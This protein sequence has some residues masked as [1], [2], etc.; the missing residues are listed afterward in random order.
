MATTTDS[1]SV[2]AATHHPLPDYQPGQ[3]LGGRFEIVEK[4]GEGMLGAVYKAR[5]KGGGDVALKVIRRGLMA[6]NTTIDQF[7]HSIQEARSVRNPRIVRVDETGEHD[8]HIF[9]TAE[10]VT[11]KTL[12]DMLNDYRSRNEDVPPREVFDVLS[13]VLDVLSDAH[14]VL[15]RNLKP[16]NIAFVEKTGPD[17]KKVRDVK[18]LDFAVAQIITPTAF[19]DSTMSREGAWYLAPEMGEFGAKADPSADLYS[20]GAIFYEMLTGYPPVGRYEMPSVIRHGEVSEKIDDLIEIA[21]NPNPQDRFHTAADMKAAL[22]STY[23]ELFGGGEVNLT[24]TL[25]LLGILIL[26]VIFASFYF[27]SSEKSPEELKAEEMA[28]RALVL[29]DV[30]ASQGPPEAPAVTDPKYADMVWIPGGKALTGHFLAFDDKGMAGER[31]EAVVDVPGYWIDKYEAHIPEQVIAPEDD[32]DTANAKR[33]YNQTQ[34][35]LLD[36]DRTWR[37][38]NSICEQAGKRLCTEDE[39]EKAC[40]G[41]DSLIYPYG[42][43]FVAKQCP[44][45]GYLPKYPY[46]EHVACR[47]A[48]GVFNLGGGAMEW[49]SSKRGDNYIVKPGALGNDGQGTRCAGRFDRAANF[50]Q[51]HVG[52]RC[53]A[54]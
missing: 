43:E 6:P 33:N 54:D 17:G 1:I 18:L 44:S 46:N 15:H 51:I 8:G 53:C 11:G 12:R 31:P 22:E 30:K 40:K 50:A 29:A 49:T 34:A 52:Y 9:C 16:E 47:S 5:Q 14:P 27:K 37:D 36:T 2:Q 10:L 21:L 38:A 25:A 20:I 32:E 26:L 19:D 41:P 28:R 4:L 23:A 48:W 35:G 13:K 45:S 39:W 42:N 3:V 7:N 24:R